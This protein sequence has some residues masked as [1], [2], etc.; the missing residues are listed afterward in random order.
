MHGLWRG[1][2]SKISKYCVRILFT[3]FKVLERGHREEIFIPGPVT[4][5]DPEGT[6]F[7]SIKKI[8]LFWVICQ[9]F[10]TKKVF[11]FFHNYV[12]TVDA[13]WWEHAQIRMHLGRGEKSATYYKPFLSFRDWY[14]FALERGRE[15]Q[16]SRKVSYVVLALQ[17]N[18]G[19]ERYRKSGVWLRKTRPCSLRPWLETH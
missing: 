1:P 8:T 18:M 2:G 19:L 12:S 16:N 5:G 10:G 11:F 6:H 14:G 13:I 15:G 17:V 7:R 9:N 4:Q 3:P